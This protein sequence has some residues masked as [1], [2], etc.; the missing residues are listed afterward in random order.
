MNERLPM[1]ARSMMCF[2]IFLKFKM[3][4][5]I[6]ISSS[7]NKTPELIIIKIEVELKISEHRTALNDLP[8]P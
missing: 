5:Y 7:E 4:R 3:Q 1:A 2:F 6:S 8:F